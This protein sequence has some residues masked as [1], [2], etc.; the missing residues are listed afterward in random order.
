MKKEEEDT[1]KKDLRMQME[2]IERKREN[3]S[4]VEGR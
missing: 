4:R 2:N 1:I 3:R